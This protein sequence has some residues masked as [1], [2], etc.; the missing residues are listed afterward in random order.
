[1]SYFT[2]FNNTGIPFMDNRI[3][4]DI[5]DLVDKT[6][7]IGDFGFIHNPD[8][9]YYSVFTISED[10][11]RFYFGGMVIT[12]VLSQI[13]T[14]GMKGELALQPVTIINKTTKDGKRDYYSL[15]FEE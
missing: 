13:E 6:V 8:G 15:V 14:D 10:T 11:N 12:D 2:K 5:H 3:K 9:T 4:G 7:H 1:M